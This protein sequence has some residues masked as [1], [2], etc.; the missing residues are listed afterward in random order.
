MGFG[1]AEI[2]AERARPAAL[3]HWRRF[4]RAR[5]ARQVSPATAMRFPTDDACKGRRYVISPLSEVT[6]FETL[7]LFDVDQP[8]VVNQA[9]PSSPTA[10]PFLRRRPSRF[11]K[12][13]E[14]LGASCTLSGSSSRNRLSILRISFQ[15]LLDRL[16]EFIQNLIG[17]AL[18][19]AMPRAA[20]FPK[21]ST[22]ATKP[23]TVLSSCSRKFTSR[24]DLHTAADFVVGPG[25]LRLD[26]TSILRVQELRWLLETRR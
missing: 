10:A 12:P 7:E 25:G 18:D 2:A 9:L 17:F 4:V 16:G 6:S 15:L 21:I 11:S 3:E 14:Q 13:A 22:P 19:N 1:K 23:S 20:S 8:L 5:P 26:V 24:V